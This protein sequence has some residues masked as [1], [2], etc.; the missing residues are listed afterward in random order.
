MA[1]IGTEVVITC[2]KSAVMQTDPPMSHDLIFLGIHLKEL[3]LRIKLRQ[4]LG[5]TRL[6][7]AMLFDVVFELGLARRPKLML[8]CTK[9][10]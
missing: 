2:P 1:I 8:R 10:I 4:F 5:D 3:G 9:A 7:L 6:F